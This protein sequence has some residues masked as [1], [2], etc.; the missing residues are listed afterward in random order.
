MLKIKTNQN[1]VHDLKSS[2]VILSVL[3]TIFTSTARR[4]PKK[5]IIFLTSKIFEFTLQLITVGLFALIVQLNFSNGD[6]A[7]S[8]V[9]EK[10]KHPFFETIF[11]L[12]TNIIVIVLGVTIILNV[13]ISFLS[14]RIL[15]R[16]SV[17]VEYYES[18]DIIK[19]VDHLQFS[20]YK[21]LLDNFGNF[22]KVSLLRLIQQNT[23][24]VGIVAR[25]LISAFFSV[26]QL[27]GLFIIIGLLGY[28]SASVLLTLTFFAATVSLIL[29]IRIGIVHS[30]NFPVSTA[31]A[32]KVRTNILSKALMLAYPNKK[33]IEAEYIKNNK[34]SAALKDYEDRF[35]II[36]IGTLIIHLITS[37]ALIILVWSF[38]STETT[39]NATFLIA[40]LFIGNIFLR[41]VQ[42]ISSYF[43]V[44]GRL[45]RQVWEVWVYKSTVA[46]KQLLQT[47]VE[48]RDSKP[49]IKLED[50]QDATKLTIEA[51]KMII[52]CQHEEIGLF[53]LLKIM[54]KASGL[55]NTDSSYFK[56]VVV[57]DHKTIDSYLNK[58][59]DDDVRKLKTTFNKYIEK[60][61]AQDTFNSDI[62]LTIFSY[63]YFEQSIIFIPIEYLKKI[64]ADLL[65]TFWNPA[66]NTTA[67][68]YGRSP[69]RTLRQYENLITQIVLIGNEIRIIPTS[70]ALKLT[71]ESLRAILNVTDNSHIYDEIDENTDSL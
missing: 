20:Q 1:V 57:A 7:S 46:N 12:P 35:R 5:I 69:D 11:A 42:Q 30:I 28:T 60:F 3:L 38:F 43:I 16:I 17:D 68:F 26:L 49:S 21:R 65:R 59:D 62:A 58:F 66:R 48:N 64:N 33:A 8:P 39:I 6:L 56:E 31:A 29:L 70:Q 14:R 67:I 45:Y 63:F 34:I 47:S 13:L 9:S 41:T 15:T 51:G 40:I 22:N 71:G 55:S 61:L 19:S 50:N 54:N 10:L 44:V 2:G 36:D 27:I 24:L 23:R 4:F 53:A 37:A 52:L 25:N 32:A 18:L